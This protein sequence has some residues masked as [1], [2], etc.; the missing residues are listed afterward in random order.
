MRLWRYSLR[1]LIPNT[2]P[3]EHPRL[4]AV[5]IGR[6]NGADFATMLERAIE[7]SGKGR[8]VKR[9]EG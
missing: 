8:E 9:I 2:L 1:S 4:G 7:R 5:A 6:M 3:H